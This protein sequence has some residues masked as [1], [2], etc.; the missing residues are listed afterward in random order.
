VESFRPSL[1][2]YARRVPRSTIAHVSASPPLI[3]DSRLSRVRL[4]ASEVWVFAHHR[5]PIPVEAS[6]HAHRPPSPIGLAAPLALGSVDHL[7]R[8]HVSC[9]VTPP[10]PPG[11]ESPFAPVRRSR[12]GD[13]LAVVSAGVTWPSSLLWAHAP[14]LHPLASYARWLGT[15]VCA[16]C[17]VPLLGGGLPDVV[18]SIAVEG[19]GP[20]PHRASAVPFPVSSRSTSAS[21][22][23]QEVRRAATPAMRAT[24]LTNRLRGCSPAVMCRLPPWRDPQV[25][26]TA[27]ALCPLGRRAVYTTHSPCGY[28]PRTVVSLRACIGPL[29][30]RDFRPLD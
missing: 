17:R 14:D 2:R 5:L 26:P 12:A 28:P 3:P 21:P 7:H 9:G 25:A 23:V 11:P 15:P 16:G 4:A 19:L 10:G 6:G 24:S 20:V 13:P 18:S 29:A 22:D 27:E 30:R 1:F 8:A